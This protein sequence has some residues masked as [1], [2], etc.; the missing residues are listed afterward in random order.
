[1]Y[2]LE[3]KKSE[4]TRK[5]GRVHYPQ[6]MI[7]FVQIKLSSDRL[8]HNYQDQIPDLTALWLI[9]VNRAAPFH[10]FV[11]FFFSRRVKIP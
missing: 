11:V 1:M 6:K 9:L 7:S 5:N 4:E 8:T 2:E 10:I 3:P